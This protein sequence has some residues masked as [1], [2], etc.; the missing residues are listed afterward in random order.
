MPADSW[1]GDATLRVDRMF[2][3]PEIVDG[4]DPDAVELDAICYSSARVFVVEMASCRVDID[5]EIDV[6]EFVSRVLSSCVRL[7]PVKKEIHV[8]EGVS[9]VTAE[10]GLC[11]LIAFRC[12]KAESSK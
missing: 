3:W 7:T 9:H 5:V 2:A 4:I 10:E 8:P 11:D 12:V 1:I 6:A